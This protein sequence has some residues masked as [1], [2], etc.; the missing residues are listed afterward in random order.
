M[1][2]DV[3]WVIQVVLQIARE[4]EVEAEVNVLIRKP[5]HTN[6][7]NILRYIVNENSF[8]FKNVLLG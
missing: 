2:S 4:I 8:V 7:T 5:N 6:I 3:P 1:Y